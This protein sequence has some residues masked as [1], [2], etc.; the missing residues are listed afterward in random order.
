MSLIGEQYYN[1]PKNVAMPG[2]PAGD[3]CRHR[4]QGMRRTMDRVGAI[5]GFAPIDGLDGTAP[6]REENGA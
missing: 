6:V 4:L 1:P 5:A 3:D 2:G